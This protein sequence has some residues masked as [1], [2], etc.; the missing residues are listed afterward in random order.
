M[1][2]SNQA[3]LLE[4]R[5][6]MKRFVKGKGRQLTLLQ[7]GERLSQHAPWYPLKVARGETPARPWLL[8]LE[9][10]SVSPS[11]R[12]VTLKTVI[13]PTTAP[14]YTAARLIRSCRDHTRCT[15][16]CRI[17]ACKSFKHAVRACH[18]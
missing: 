15:K 2:A 18:S 6:Q 9:P 4:H 13:L 10:W 7:N 16:E 11:Y 14:V 5:H 3:K 12:M 17:S 1:Q 8:S